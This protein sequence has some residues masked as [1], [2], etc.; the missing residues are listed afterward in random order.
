VRR[1]AR[2]VGLTLLAALA[3]AQFVPYGH[4]HENPRVTMD[5]PWAS[6]RAEA[7]ARESCYDCHSNETEWPWYTSVAPM[8]FLAVN[9]VKEGRHEVNFSEWDRPQEEAD[10]LQRVIRRGSMPPK[11]YTFI[12]RGASLD[13]EEKRI[14]LDAIRQLPG[15]E[16]DPDDED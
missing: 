7:I 9:D 14:L 11:Q 8:S 12:H 1:V 6:A 13:A 3:I 16:D 2:I 10:D 15:A 5:A 4:D